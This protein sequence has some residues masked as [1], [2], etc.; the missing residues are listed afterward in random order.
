MATFF[1]V[2]RGQRNIMTVTLAIATLSI[3]GGMQDVPT[4]GAALQS[5][6]AG[7][8]LFLVLPIMY[9]R[10]VLKEPLS[11]IGF[12][13]TRWLPALFWGVVSLGIGGIGLLFVAENPVF[14]EAY[15]LPSVVEQSFLWFVAYE[16]IA[17]GGIALM[18]EVFFRGLVMKLWLSPLGIDIVADMQK[19][20]GYFSAAN[21]SANSLVWIM[22][23]M[24]SLALATKLNSFGA[25]QYPSMSMRGGTFGGIPVIVT[26][27]VAS[28]VTSGS[29]V[30]LVSAENILLADDGV[31]L[32]DA[33]N[34]VSI[35]MD[36]EPTS[37]ATA[38]T[39]ASLV[40]M[41]QTNSTAFRAERWINWRT[42]RT[43]SVVYITAASWGEA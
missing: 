43:P 41:W 15:R 22:P 17:V 23:S 34:Q 18:Y 30:V 19:A 40:S 33:S 16:V 13:N 7:L 31:I 6:I 36:G 5:A 1:S 29:T 42:A 2:F 9:C 27:Y 3:F 28:D 35:E 32:I 38:G 21:I 25:P 37:D 8:V 20:L 12:G 11:S 4:I 10:I 24:M 39:G 14:K 26:D